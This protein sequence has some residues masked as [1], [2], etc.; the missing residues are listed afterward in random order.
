MKVL[1]AYAIWD[2]LKNMIDLL[3]KNHML[4]KIV[5]IMKK[6]K[7]RQRLRG[8][9][10]HHRCN[11]EFELGLKKCVFHALPYEGEYNNPLCRAP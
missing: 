6:K 9:E 10:E 7:K 4:Q 2:R 1:D 8:I 5:K 11:S 3:K